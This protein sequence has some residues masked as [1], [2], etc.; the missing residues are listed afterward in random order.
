MPVID[1]TQMVTNG[2]PVFPGSGPVI[3]KRVSNL[4]SEGYNELRMEISTHT[5]THI[6]CGLH[7]LEEGFDTVMTETQRFYGKGL[8]IDCRSI[9]H[10]GIITVEVLQP[11]ESVIRQSEFVI[12]KTGWSRFWSDPQYFSD[13]PVLD[14]KAAAYLACFSLK[15]TGVDA[16]GFD[17]VDSVKLSVH[18]A[19]LSKGI[20]LI[21]NLTNL[22]ALPDK[23]F[24]FCCFPL[25][26]K[27]GD[28]SPVRAVGI[29]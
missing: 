11:Y 18:K 24:I 1:L 15:G 9:P 23:G 6:D 22:D 12:F 26:I 2:M 29:V 16:P 25:K 5:G 28:G 17:P 19:L 13:F 21:E 7:L 10:N 14:D 20:V 27:G 3:V 8:V 4:D